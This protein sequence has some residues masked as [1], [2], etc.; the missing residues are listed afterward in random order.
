MAHEAPTQTPEPP[1][2]PEQ[3]PPVTAPRWSE[4][5]K[6]VGGLAAVVTGL[7][8]V[9]LVALA[10]IFVVSDDGSAVASVAGGAFS[11]VGTIVGAYFGVKVGTDGK[12]ES[13][14]AARAFALH[15]PEGEAEKAKQ[16]ARELAQRQR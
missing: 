16:H 6:I 13:E 8:V 7:T 15:V 1:G 2:R 12:Q 3:A 10:G 4:G 9:L 14:A 5:L 11:V